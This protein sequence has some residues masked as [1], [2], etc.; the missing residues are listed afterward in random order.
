MSDES[1]ASTAENADQRKMRDM[2]EALLI[3]SVRQHE[4]AELAQTRELALV[5]SEDRYRTLFEL[6]PIAVYSCA[7]SGMI[8]DFNRTAVE[9]WGRKPKPGDTD[10]RFFGSFKNAFGQH[11]AE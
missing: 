2:N 9:L 11:L 3:S 6:A 10:E 5:E 8:L 7:V 1:S 4:L